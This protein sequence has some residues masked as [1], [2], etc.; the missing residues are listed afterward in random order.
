M[1]L[2]KWLKLDHRKIVPGYRFF[3]CSFCGQ[4]DKIKTRDCH[5]LSVEECKFCGTDN[6]PVN[7][8]EHPEWES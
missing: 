8:E 7:F 1:D 5:T 3:K 2:S 6:S 4:E